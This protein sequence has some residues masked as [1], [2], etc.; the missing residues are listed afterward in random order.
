MKSLVHYGNPHV[1]NFCLSLGVPEFTASTLE[2]NQFRCLVLFI[3]FQ[4]RKPSTEFKL[5]IET[6]PKSFK[7]YI[8]FWP[9]VDLDK[10]NNTFLMNLINSRIREIFYLNSILRKSKISNLNFSI[11]EIK[12]AHIAVSSRMFGIY[13][14]KKLYYTCVPYTDLF[15]FDPVLNT[16]WKIHLKSLNDF[17]VLKA[18]KNIGIGQQIFVNYGKDDN[19]QLLT[20][21][22]FT[23]KNNPFPAETNNFYVKFQNKFI[24]NSIHEQKSQLLVK[25]I[26]KLK[27]YENFKASNKQAQRMQD[28]RLFNLLLQALRS[29][30]NKA[31]IQS[32]KGNLKLTPNTENIYRVLLTEDKLIEANSGYLRQFIEILNGGKSIMSKYKG[33]RV[34]K[35]NINYFT[36][37]LD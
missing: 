26:E 7:E 13:I 37:V 1:A 5:Y 27:Q 18:T 28:L 16:T 34:V 15:N 2:K 6:I 33:S 25:S 31:L 23:L 20:G 14:S 17:F 9:K 12:H 21:Y 8:L 10:I 19:V 24:W 36:K 32:L 22:G 29:Y 11:N 3:L 4:L 35:Q 30:D